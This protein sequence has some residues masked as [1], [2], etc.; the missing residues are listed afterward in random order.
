MGSPRTYDFVEDCTHDG[1]KYRMLN[2]VDEFTRN[3]PIVTA[4]FVLAER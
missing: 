4:A 2:V 1:R 3:R